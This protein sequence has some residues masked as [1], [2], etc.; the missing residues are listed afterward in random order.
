MLTSGAASVLLFQKREGKSEGLFG[1]AVGRV[2]VRAP[3]WKEIAPPAS[4]LLHIFAKFGS[5]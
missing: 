5:K 4:L 1:A 2:P 3:L